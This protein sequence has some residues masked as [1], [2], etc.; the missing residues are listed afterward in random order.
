MIDRKSAV[1]GLVGAVIACAVMVA[2]SG[3]L[4]RA[5][6]LDHPEI[7]PEAMQ[8]LQDRELASAVNANRAAYETPFGSAWAGAAD[9]DVVLVE[10]FDYACVFCRK[11]NPDVERLLTEDKKL[12]VVWREFPVLGEDSVAAAQ[13]SLA[14]AKQGKFRQYHDSLFA[15]ARPTPEAVAAAQKAAGVLPATV[16][17]DIRAE[18]DRNYE[19]ATAVRATGTPLFVVGDKVLQ[20][21][22]GYEAL[23]EAVAA[24]RAR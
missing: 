2:A 1:S 8:R 4:I 13:A 15:T 11:S 5:Y 12:K 6:I 20:G 21:A 18:I 23:K 22:V 3:P 16:T 10:F 19:L 7:L 14:A 17:P 24:A 9:G